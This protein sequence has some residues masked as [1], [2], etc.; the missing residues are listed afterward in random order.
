MRSKLRETRDRLRFIQTRA[1]GHALSV[2]WDGG[3]KQIKAHL[4]DQ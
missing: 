4:W 1:Y 2:D 3:G